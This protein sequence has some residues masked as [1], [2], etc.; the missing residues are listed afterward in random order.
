MGSRRPTGGHAG[1]V[2]LPRGKSSARHRGSFTRPSA[3]RANYSKTA[4]PESSA[5]VCKIAIDSLCR[6]SSVEVGKGV[7][8]RFYMVQIIHVHGVVD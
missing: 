6:Q 1:R 5:T 8:Y 3:E 2:T 4:T 7:F